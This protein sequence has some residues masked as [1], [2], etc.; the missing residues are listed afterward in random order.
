MFIVSL[1]LGAALLAQQPAADPPK[2]DLAVIS[3]RLGPCSADFTV[4]DA[5]GKP[6]Y[7]AIVHV[8]IRYGFMSIKR[9]DLEVGTNSD[10][11]ARV[12]GLPEKARPLTYDVTKDMLKGTAQ[13]DLATNCKATYTVA[14]K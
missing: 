9:M 12:E 14:L 11:K 5:D 6:I 8:R 3:G 10:G 4:T 1:A 2:P 13:Q 7:A